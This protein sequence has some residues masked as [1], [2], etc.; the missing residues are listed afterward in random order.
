[1]APTASPPKEVVLRILISF[2]TP[3]SS[4]GFEP[5]NVES[6]GNDDNHYNTNND[7]ICYMRLILYFLKA[8]KLQADLGSRAV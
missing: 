3:S 2:K 8:D 5:A 4:V 7:K 1:M 6:S